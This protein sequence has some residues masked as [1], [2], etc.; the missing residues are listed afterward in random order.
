[1][2]AQ[3][4]KHLTIVLTLLAL[5][6]PVMP[7]AQP[8][9]MAAS[10]AVCDNSPST[11]KIG[12]SISQGANAAAGDTTPSSDCTKPGNVN[13]SN[14]GTIGNKIVNIFSIIVGIVAIIMLIYG[15]FRYI[16]SGGASERV[17]NAKNTII[18]AVIGLVI[19]ALAQVI[20]HFVLFQTNKAVGW[21][22]SSSE[23]A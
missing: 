18:Y 10:D 21:K 23:V 14:L 20:V 15:G 7:V 1:M 16:T 19:V 17:S 9:A 11:T 4:K 12:D 8:I 6:V 5:T 3:I 13:Q 22:P 2:I